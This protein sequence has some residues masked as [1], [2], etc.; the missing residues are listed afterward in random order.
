[1]NFTRFPGVADSISLENF[2][3]T[4]TVYKLRAVMTARKQHLTATYNLG[5]PMRPNVLLASSPFFEHFCFVVC[6]SAEL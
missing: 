4:N 2:V 1:M 6:F 3:V 5:G